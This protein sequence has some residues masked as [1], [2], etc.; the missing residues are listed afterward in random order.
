EI[1]FRRAVVA[2]A[3]G[4]EVGSTADV[5]ERAGLPAE[6]QSGAAGSI[7]PGR[8]ALRERGLGR[9]VFGEDLDNPA[10]GVPVERRE[11]SSHHLYPLGRAEIE[12]GGLP[13]AVGRR[14]GDPVSVEANAANAEL[15]ARP[16]PARRYLQVLGV[17]LA[18][19]HDH[20]GYP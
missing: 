13:L 7:A 10:R 11:R 19:L 8:A 3:G 2:V 14:G 17:V 4:L 20:A 12:V 15:R 9:T 6:L 1:L 16:E 18:V 5:V